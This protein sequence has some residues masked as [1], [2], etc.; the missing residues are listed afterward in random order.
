MRSLPLFSRTV[1]SGIVLLFGFGLGKSVAEEEGDVVRG[2]TYFDQNCAFCH[3]DELG[4]QGNPVNRVGPSLVGVF[5]RPA[6]TE[7]NFNYTKA[8]GESHLTWDRATLDRFLTGPMKLVP[9]TKMPVLIP[10][11]EKRHDV[12]SYLATLQAPARSP[13]TAVP[14]APPTPVD[15]KNESDD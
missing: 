1:F 10:D 8:L 2:K 15:P 5:G 11:T 3:A 6:A 12:I 9:G 4:M 14:S 13:G 7:P